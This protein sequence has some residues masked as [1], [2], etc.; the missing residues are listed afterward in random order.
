MGSG[1]GLATSSDI[2]TY[3]TYYIGVL[4]TIYPYYI[5]NIY[6]YKKIHVLRFF[7]ESFQNNYQVYN[8]TTKHSLC[9]LIEVK[10]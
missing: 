9:W 4:F 1:G 7:S 3:Y 8:M 6:K 2:N 10:T 5:H